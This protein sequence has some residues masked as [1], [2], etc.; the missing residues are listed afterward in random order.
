MSLIQ[1][2][3][4]NGHDPYRYLTDVLGAAADTAEL[5]HRR[6]APAP[7]GIGRSL[8]TRRIT[9]SG[10]RQKVLDARLPQHGGYTI[11]IVGSSEVDAHRNGKWGGPGWT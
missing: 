6:A 4:L 3:K 9:S 10:P 5:P 1:S 7:L 8:L 11:A 2:A